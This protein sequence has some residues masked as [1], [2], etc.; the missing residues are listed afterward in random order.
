MWA[1]FLGCSCVMSSVLCYVP[2]VNCGMG[3]V[4]TESCLVLFNCFWHIATSAGQLT[5]LLNA[6]WRQLSHFQSII[7]AEPC[8]SDAMSPTTYL[9]AH[10][11][12]DMC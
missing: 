12:A 11:L 4:P 5:A 3:L 8:A 10:L 6:G 7:Q 1:D 2:E 9:I